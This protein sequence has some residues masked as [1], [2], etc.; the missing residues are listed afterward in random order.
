MKLIFMKLKV[1]GTFFLILAFMIGFF[2]PISAQKN[3]Q[4]ISIHGQ[5]IDNQGMPLP[6]VSIRLKNSIIVTVSDNK[7]NYTLNL[8]QKVGTLIFSFIGYLSQE[9]PISN[10][11][12]INVTLKEDIKSLD[13]VVVVGYG[14]QKKRDLTGSVATVNTKEMEN[15]A[16]VG[17]GQAL[18]G[19]LAGVQISQNSGEPNA[20]VGIIIRGVGTFG[21]SSSPLIVIDGIITNQGL[22]DI[23]NNS[24]ESLVILK[25]A[26]AAAIYGSRG[27]NGVVLITTKRGSI[28]KQS[29]QFSTYYSFDNIQ[30]INKTVDAVTYAHMMNEYFVNSG[31]VAPFT[32][33]EIASFTK[34]TNWQREIFRT[35]GKQN[36]ELSA[37]GGTAKNLYAISVGYYK[38]DGIVINDKYDRYNFHVNNDITP[39]KGLKIGTSLGLSYGTRKQ[40][41]SQGA[42]NEAMI[43]P[44][45]EP[46]YLANGN[47][48]IASH[49]GEPVTMI[50]PLIDALLP[51]NKSI[52]TRALINTFAEYEIITGLKF[53]TSLGIE[54]YNVNTTNF[55]PTYDYGVSNTSTSAGLTRDFY[56]DKNLQWDNTLTYSK[57][58]NKKHI[59]EVLGGWTFQK[60]RDE[61]LSGYREGFSSNDVSQQILNDGS[62]N[63][64]SR[65]WY[66]DWAI[67]SYLGRLNYSYMNKY[68]FTSNLRVDQ[69]SRFPK[70]NRTGVF[71]SF[72]LGY[73][74]SEENFMKDILGP[75]NFLKLKASYGIIGNQDINNYPYQ[76]T[77]SPSQYY[78]LGTNVVVGTAPTSNVNSNIT[79]EKTATMNIGAEVRLLKN[80]LNFIVDYYNKLSSDILV[81][82]ALPAVSGLSGN[83]YENIGSAR[84]RGFE[85]TLSYGNM[86]EKKDLTYEVGFNLTT[87]RNKVIKLSTD[88][89]IITQGGAQ[90]QYEYRTEQG[91]E[92]N[93]YYGYVMCGI[94][95]TQ[96]EINKWATQPNAAPGD[97]KFKD[98]NHDGV[99]NS[100]DREYIGSSMIKEMIGFNASVKYKNFDFSMSL[101]GQFGRKM[102]ILTNGFNLVRMGEITSAM[103]NDRWT[104][105]GTSNYVPRLVAGDPNNNSRM[106]TFWLRSQDYIRIQNVQ[107][108]YNLPLK[109]TNRVKSLRLYLAG[110]NL[111]TFNSFPGYDPELG[112][113]TYPIPRS[114]YLG[115]N[116]GF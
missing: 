23:D 33:D 92:I 30:R 89:T 61:D 68:L 31:A 19:K 38:G 103:Y 97:M 69:S 62:K 73:V 114:I 28:Q 14:T 83:P 26:S 46:A 47:F 13:E 37:T 116:I 82:V 16:V 41:N 58:I 115:I 76:I 72:S 64:Q 111:Y 101:N 104:G 51:I 17:P 7:G 20:G 105:P 9:V 12:F 10:L 32:N 4:K 11:D 5:V 25:D 107:L 106:S 50:S 44:P 95:Q 93:E 67:Q 66:S 88:A 91:H 87:N 56:E 65:G 29:L 34:S 40:G 21:A 48:G 27:A 3:Q 22:A 36:Y 108:G 109:T 54:Y 85:F 94:F 80:K 63:D 74:L 100:L 96:D 8:P 18:Q 75:V 49:N 70:A 24:I 112:T 52:T 42:I 57:T 43:Y 35:G 81:S 71:P 15:N 99:I 77:L 39:F 98:L 60:T 102:Y 78:S 45:T 2:N 113:G 59:F 84:N 86:Q 79:W 1:L 110:Q 90:N 53:K 6:G 55:N